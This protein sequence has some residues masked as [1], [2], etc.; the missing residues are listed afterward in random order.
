MIYTIKPYDDY[1][2]D[3]IINKDCIKVQSINEILKRH[4]FIQCDSFEAN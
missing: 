3:S 1:I 2:Y 4:T